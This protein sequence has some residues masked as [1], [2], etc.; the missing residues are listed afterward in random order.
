MPLTAG[1]RLGRYEIQST[2]G[3]GGMGEV[4]LAYDT[5]LARTV[6]VKTLTVREGPSRQALGRFA[7][8][9][10]AASALNHP[11]IVHV[12][13]VDEMDGLHF[14]VMEFVEGETLRK[15]IAR[16]GLKLDEALE[17]AAQVASALSAAHAAGVIHRDI[18]PENIIMRPDGYIKVLDFGL[19]K[20]PTRLPLRLDAGDSTL[21]EVLTDPGTILGTI[22]YMSPEQARGVAVD[23]R[24]DVWSLGAVI[25]EMIAGR[26][27]FEAAT[28]SDALAA[29]LDRE[30]Q[31]LSQ[32]PETVSSV[33]TKALTKNQEER[34]QTAQELLADL[35][36]AKHQLEVDLEAGRP[37]LDGPTGGGAAPAMTAATI[38]ITGR[39]SSAEYLVDLV[40]RHRRGSLL[41]AAA[42]LLVAAAVGYVVLSRWP[43]SRRS[44]QHSPRR[45]TVDQGLQSGPTWSP[46]GRWI[47]Y[48]S[49]RG[50]N[51][52]I[53]LQSIDGGNP[54]P[55][56]QSKSDEL[57]P[58]WSP[59]G[60]SI[61]FRSEGEQSGLFI[62]P[63]FGGA[64][65]SNISVFGYRPRWSSDSANILFL[66]P[67][68]RLSERP[69][70]YVYSRRGNSSR[71]ILAGGA[72][73]VRG[74]NGGMVEWHP[75]GR[76]VSYWD[77]AR[78]FLT[79]PVDGGAAVKSSVAPEVESAIKD[80][81][82]DLLLF[83]WAPSG[84]ALYFEGLARGVR[85]LWKVTVDPQTL[86][87]VDGPERLNSAGLGPETGLAPSR[88]G[89][90]LAFST[91]N[92]H[93]GIWLFPFDARSG[94][95]VNVTEGRSVTPL[96][97]SAGFPDLSPDGKKLLYAAW[98]R[99][100]DQQQIWERSLDDGRDR[101]LIPGDEFDRFCPR[102]LPDSRQIIYSRFDRHQGPAPLAIFN[103]EGNRELLVTSP[104]RG[105]D[106]VYDVSPDGRR[107]LGS[108]NRRAR[109]QS[110]LAIF[111]LTGAEAAPEVA[112]LAF[113][114]GKELWAPRLSPDG[115]WVCFIA[116][117]EKSKP[118]VSVIYVMPFAGGP[119]VRMTEEDVWADKP[120]WSPDGRTIYFIAN[121]NSRFLNVWKRNFDPAA[122]RP[123]G[124][125]AQVTT[126]ENPGRLIPGNVSG[127]ELSFN[128]KFLALP[129][130]EVTG[131]I[132]VIDDVDP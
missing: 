68:A 39:M 121:Y 61:A 46:D 12:Y 15:R 33:V 26:P 36:R 131:S 13:E 43:I 109:D 108:T 30:P 96:D 105:Q 118:G 90:Q 120:R 126:F 78:A 119:W 11:H 112:E 114:P 95:Q 57:E 84:K 50:G 60:K 123:V 65:A 20:M 5:K 42:I 106:Y 22:N 41:T 28:A 29:V 107:A 101:L 53:W 98:V 7:Q 80:L 94:R 76:R 77:D 127:L 32:I 116:Q 4:Y 38:H 110:A 97:V 47:A 63:P 67:G 115:R 24:A 52:D 92:Q 31:P 99:G 70:V 56:T 69:R 9:A 102:W 104:G 25:Y 49:N 19:A 64:M 17:I 129:I 10:R 45:L 71:E 48:S 66:S 86:A 2:L 100:N 103:P 93:V 113:D 89:K 58:D 34:Y 128:K 40:Q 35:R 130:R 16:G 117:M 132:W 125:P 72:E 23:A 79:V 3:V 122:G 124:P 62:V 6:A 27:P 14:I 21:S 75:D 59:D 8:E 55:V 74:V 18:K 73:A 87:W 81:G 82:V 88:D 85:N 54:I 91:G 111:P 1:T 37:G 51:F 83:R 44:A